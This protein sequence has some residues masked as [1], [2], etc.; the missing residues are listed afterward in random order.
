[1]DTVQIDDVHNLENAILKQ[2]EKL[3]QMRKLVKELKFVP[4]DPVGYYSCVTYK[5]IDGGKMNIDFDPFEIDYVE[6][7]DSNENVL[8]KFVVPLGIQMEKTDFSTLDEMSI[9][10]TFLGIFKAKSIT[11]ISEIWNDPT[12]VMELA[13]YACIFEKIIQES[14]KNKFLIMKD[15]LLRTKALKAEYFKDLI[16]ILSKSKNIKLVGVSKSS[17][18]LSMISS[19]MHLEK[20]F[21]PDKTGYVAIPLALELMAYTWTGHGLIK[22]R[23]EPLDYALGQLYV[24]KLSPKSDLLV[25]TEIPYDLK[26]DKPIYN[27][28]EIN[29]IFGHLVKDSMYSYPNLGYAQTIMRA[30]EKAVKLG[31]TAS[32]IRDKIMDKCLDGLDPELQNTIREYNIF[33]ESVKKGSL[34]GI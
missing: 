18:L 8:L 22:E 17:K 32:I 19:A 30:H 5:A 9:I 23:N 6:I 24:A 12:K 3:N 7:A 25:T 16:Q 26:E 29:E 2:R 31:F 14:D 11:D 13:E 21:P 4:V 20:I 33:K 34:G 27:S 15:G 10:K 28:G 1:M